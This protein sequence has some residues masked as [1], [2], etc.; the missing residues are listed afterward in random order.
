VSKVASVTDALDAI[1]LQVPDAAILDINLAGEQSF[2]VANALREHGVPFLFATGYGE[3]SL[4]DEFAGERTM[5]KPYLPHVLRSQ[6]VAL[7]NG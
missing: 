4:P 1:A 6:L 3:R 7:L 2:P 5:Q